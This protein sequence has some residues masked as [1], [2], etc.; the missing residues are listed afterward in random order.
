MA[1]V[2]NT[3]SYPMMTTN[4]VAQNQNL[5]LTSAKRLDISLFLYTL[6]IVQVFCALQTFI[7]KH[8][9]EIIFFLVKTFAIFTVTPT[10]S[11]K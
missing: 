11:D 7:L 6:K 5:Y 3:I 2:K 4:Q 9:R 10:F 8:T 1:R